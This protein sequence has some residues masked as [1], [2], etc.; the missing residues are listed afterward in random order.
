[1]VP[2]EVL[3]P[4]W[5]NDDDWL[6]AW[7]DYT[8]IPC[9]HQEGPVYTGPDPIFPARHGPGCKGHREDRMFGPSRDSMIDRDYPAPYKY[10]THRDIEVDEKYL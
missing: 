1:M 4:D 3:M 6:N 8:C 2:P 9:D 5:D 7:L 10:R